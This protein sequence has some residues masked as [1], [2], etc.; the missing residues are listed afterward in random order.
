MKKF[1]LIAVLVLVV[2]GCKMFSGSARL[3]TR[4]ETESGSLSSFW[5]GVHVQGFACA[6]DAIYLGVDRS[7][8]FKFDWDG[9]FLK[10][11]D[12][13]NH[14]GDVC[15]YNGRLYTSVD[16]LAGPRPKRSG[17][18]QVYDAELNL[19]REAFI[20]QGVDGICAKDGILYLGMNNVPAQHRVNQIGR[21][22]AKTLEFLDRV[23][24]DYG[25]D[26]SWGTQNITTDG[27]NFWVEF[28]SKMPLAVFDRDW[29]PVRS[30]D[31][32][33]SQGFDFLP[34]R[35]Q[36]ERPTFACG[37][38]F[39]RGDEPAYCIEFFEFDGTQMVPCGIENGCFDKKKCERR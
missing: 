26:T 11:V 24:I 25:H 30:L 29:K 1:A 34:M 7:G 4:F 19:L 12:A 38:N 2:T 13:P 5:K 17:I 6:P 18:V 36:G 33:S 8:I 15:W 20:E 27:E 39:R 37:K 31:F 10:H 23:D 21:M 22:D 14:T 9:H 3:L 16:V 35:F 28:Y 32:K